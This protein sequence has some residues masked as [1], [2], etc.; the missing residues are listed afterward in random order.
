MPGPLIA[1]AWRRPA[2]VVAAVGV[3]IVAVLAAVVYHGT[4]T[5]FDDWVFDRLYPE[6]GNGAAN[7]M[8]GFTTPAV[9]ISLLVAVF[10]GAL[11]VRR[12]DV[13]ALAA[14]GPGVTLLITEAVLKPITSR[15]L[16]PGLV[17]NPFHITVNGVYPSGHEAT[18]ASTACVLV[19][20]AGQLPMRRRTRSVFAAVLAAWTVVAAIGLVRSFWHYATDTIGA[21]CLSAAVVLCVAMGIDRYADVMIRRVLAVRERQLT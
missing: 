2:Y 8:L 10:G 6:I 17:L 14:L 12:W 7:A 3:V 19:L 4:S 13:A 1:D 20:V 15:V 9:S 18:V 5:S 16:G 21:I 11:L